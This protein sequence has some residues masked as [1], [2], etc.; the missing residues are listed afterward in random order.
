MSE[1]LKGGIIMLKNLVNFA[2]SMV[3]VSIMTMI[4]YVKVALG[5]AS[6]YTNVRS[7]DGK[8][9]TFTRFLIEFGA[10]KNALTLVTD[11]G[12]VAAVHGTVGAYFI[13]DREVDEKEMVSHFE[14]GDYILVSCANGT[15]RDFTMDGRTFVRDQNTIDGEHC[16]VLIVTPWHDLVTWAGKTVDIYML[17]CMGEYKAAWNN[18]WA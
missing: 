7:V 4:T 12:M 8:K 11:S 2:V 6:R 10:L 5:S 16:S 18:I 15:H 13:D 3:M 1:I 14:E 17:I 9:Y